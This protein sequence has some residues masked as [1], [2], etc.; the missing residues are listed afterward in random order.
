MTHST[1]SSPSASSDDLTEAQIQRNQLAAQEVER[2]RAQRAA[3]RI[4]EREDEEQTV[5]DRVR[6]RVLDD[7]AA[8]E[9]KRITEPPAPPFDMGTLADV[10]ARPADPPMRAEG[11]IPW[12]GSALVVAQRKTGKTTLLLNY[13]RAL[14]TG[15]RFLGEFDMIPLAAHE[16]VAFLN[17]EVSAAQLARW[18]HDAG[19]PDDRILLV[20]LRGRRNPLGHP[21][22]RAA[23]AAALR[24]QSVAS[25]I[26]D[27]FGRAYTGVSQN[28]NG[29]VQSFLVG[30]E[31]FARAEVGALDLMLATHA[32]WDGERTR[33]ASALEDWGDVIITLTRDP[34]EEERRFMK[35]MG[36][37]VDVAEDELT[38]D[39]HR[40]L[41][42]TGNGS[43]KAQKGDRDAA[44][45]A[46]FVVR[47][48]RENPGCSK[49]AAAA[50]IAEMADA[51]DVDLGRGRGDQRLREA[52]EFAEKK[53]HLRVERHGKGKGYS[54]YEA[55]LST[56][57]TTTT[58]PPPGGG[59]PTTTTPV[60]G[61]VGGGTGAGGPLSTNTGGGGQIIERTLAGA[62]RRIDMRS[63]EVLE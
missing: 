41:T 20:N 32:G 63:G 6:R 62:R 2:L 48:A 13:A 26:V 7:K 24:A 57:T 18:A 43:R 36:R 17:Y 19:I 25:L 47:A 30:L 28:D 23:L 5:A 38:M 51:P 37:D 4:L 45:L 50:A 39:E 54:L 8:L 55:E 9:Y 52:I 34:D 53:G 35:A 58:A 42:R 10:L 31:E 60:Y 11:L 33:G 1:D 40:T 21:D 29:E 12:S 46:V 27:P 22:D 16:R 14:I 56:T 61:V 44:R 15:E 59:P 49:S 3:L